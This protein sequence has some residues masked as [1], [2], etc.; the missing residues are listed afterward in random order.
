MRL[1]DDFLLPRLVNCVCSSP[2]VARQRAR[3]V[4]HAEGRV[5]DVGFG[6]GLN[7]PFYDRGRV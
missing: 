1:Y 6:S 7:L 2:V 4:P 3:V 5:L